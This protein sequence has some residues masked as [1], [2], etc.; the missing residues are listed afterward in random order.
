MKRAICL[1]W[2]ALLVSFP[3]FAQGAKLRT[4]LRGHAGCVRSVA[5]SPDGKV[6][7]S[8]SYDAT[9]R[10]WNVSTG[11]NT[12][13]LRMPDAD[14]PPWVSSVAYSA[15]GKRLASASYDNMIRLWNVASG[16]N[17]ATLKG[18]AD[19]VQVVTWSP[20]GKTLASVGGDETHQ[21]RLWNA[22]TGKSITALGKDEDYVVSV[23]WSP[24]GKTLVSGD[25]GGRT[26]LWNMT[27]GRMRS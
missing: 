12:A 27:K 13:T 11:K 5:W 16:K 14:D 18:H 15:D 10:L 19:W 2:I 6:L 17:T 8:G 26:R 7:A 23:A 24:D 4:T 9:V 25:I 20:D 3:L 21:V 22:S 1:T